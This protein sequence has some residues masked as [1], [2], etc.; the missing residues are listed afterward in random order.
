MDLY[1]EFFN[2]TSTSNS[3]WSWTELASLI[4]AYAETQC[5]ISNST[6]GSG[7]SQ[8][9]QGG[10]VWPDLQIDWAF[11]NSNAQANQ[12]ISNWTTAEWKLWVLWYVQYYNAFEAYLT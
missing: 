6:A 5:A 4:Q 9:I 11:W 2:Q 1:Y 7:P 8:L 10:D 3:T 12:N